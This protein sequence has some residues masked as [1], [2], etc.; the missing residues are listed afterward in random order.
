MSTAAIYR[1]IEIRPVTW[2]LTRMIKPISA[3][4]M[5]ATCPLRHWYYEQ[6]YVA[7]YLIKL[8]CYF[9]K[10]VDNVL[11]FFLNQ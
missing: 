10:D 1:V 7:S 3:L 9:S 4:K 2:L 11:N 8:F 6:N 5:E